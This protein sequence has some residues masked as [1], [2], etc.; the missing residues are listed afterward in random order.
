MKKNV[1]GLEGLEEYEDKSATAKIKSCMKANISVFLHGKPGTGKSQRVKE[2]DPDC[3]TIEMN[4]SPIED[5]AG[6]NVVLNGEI[7]KVMPEWLRSLKEK[8]E[9]EPH[10]NHILFL[11]EFT[12]APESIQKLAYSIVLDR[13]V[14]NQWKLPQNVRVIAAGN[15]V[16][17][18]IVA[19]ELLEPMKDRVAHITVEDDYSEWREWAYYHRIHPEILRYLDKNPSLRF[20]YYDEL[21]GLNRKIT[22]RTWERASKMLYQTGSFGDLI[23]ILPASTVSSMVTNHML[24][25]FPYEDIS[26]YTPERHMK[27]CIEADIPVFLHGKPGEGKSSRVEAL[28][29]N[30][31]VLEINLLPVEDL[32][33]MVVCDNGTLEKKKPMW[34][35]RLEETCAKEPNKNH[36]LF[37]DELTNAMPVVQG[38]AYSL[39]LDRTVGNTWKLPQNVRIVAAG[40]STEDS[41]AATEIPEPLVDRFAHVKVETDIHQWLEWAAKNDIHPAIMSYLAENHEMAFKCQE[42]GKIVTTPRTWERA[43]NQLWYSYNL[44]TLT[45]IIGENFTNDFLEFCSTRVMSKEEI[46]SNNGTFDIH[47]V[48]HPFALIPN[49]LSTEDFEV[50]KVRDFLSENFPQVVNLFESLWI[51]RSPEKDERKHIIEKLRKKDR[52]V[53]KDIRPSKAYTLLENGEEYQLNENMQVINPYRYHKGIDFEEE[54]EILP[55]EEEENYLGEDIAEEW[56]YMVGKQGK[57]AIIRPN[58][59][60]KSLRK[61]PGKYEKKKKAYDL[62]SR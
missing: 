3:T 24:D 50:E 33:G 54:E 27:A 12:N 13:R 39:V 4:L 35:T 55:S 38:L 5:F 21:T 59:T 16:E 23:S 15:E 60:V 26:I 17:D 28:D 57:N 8:C 32:S 7:K 46:L 45:G 18:S 1:F 14:G 34:L 41:I 19:T 61:S 31:Q 11:D 49:L 44:D 47:Q 10:K 40:N 37:L 6:M 48:A 25:G 62:M 20:S 42:N 56:D 2:L 43:S 53:R 29:P 52:Y 30:A 9:K 51:N 36:I 58:L 22:P